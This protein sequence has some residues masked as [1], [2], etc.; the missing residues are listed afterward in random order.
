M[1]GFLSRLI[2]VSWVEQ[3]TCDQIYEKFESSIFSF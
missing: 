1:R 2:N 3:T